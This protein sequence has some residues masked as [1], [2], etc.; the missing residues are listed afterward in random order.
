MKTYKEFSISLQELADKETFISRKTSD[1][2]RK[3]IEDQKRIEN[4]KRDMKPLGDDLKTSKPSAL[5]DQEVESDSDP[6]S[7]SVNIKGNVDNNYQ[8]KDLKKQHQLYK[9]TALK[10][11]KVAVKEED[12]WQD[13]I[14]RK[15]KDRKER[16]IGQDELGTQQE[17][18]IHYQQQR[19]AEQRKKIGQKVFPR[20]ERSRVTNN[21]RQ[22]LL[23][24]EENEA[25]AENCSDLPA[26]E[27][28]KER[29]MDI[30][31][32]NK[33]IKPHHKKIVAKKK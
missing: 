31:K 7:R 4:R 15:L 30:E 28:K 9:G 12:D 21:E 27:K 6:V 19:E 25:N 1:M 2:T 3:N 13:V 11:Q 14:R 29:Q 5:R 23:Q 20:D 18:Q 33:K 24:K 16:T 10:D 26:D 17:K 32:I 8:G 22:A